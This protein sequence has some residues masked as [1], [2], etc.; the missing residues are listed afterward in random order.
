MV[1][2]ND[3]TSFTIETLAGSGARFVLGGLASEG[4]VNRS[5]DL[6]KGR[7]PSS[8]KSGQVPFLHLG[9]KAGG[10]VIENRVLVLELRHT[11]SV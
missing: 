7:L 5:T 2:D 6:A 9:R 3:K 11:N 10:T 4:E 8:Q 1:L